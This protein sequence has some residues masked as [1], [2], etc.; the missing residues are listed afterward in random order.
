M[1]S[2][3]LVAV[4]ALVFAMPGS[5]QVIPAAEK[6]TVNLSVGGGFDYWWGDWGGAVHRFGPSAWLT[7][8]I[9]HG[10]GINV[11][12]HSMI[13]GGGNNASDHYK[14][15]AGKGGLI[16]TY[17]RWTTIRPYAKAEAGYASLS[18]PSTGLS[19]THQNEH[20]WSVGGGG[21]YRVWKRLWTRVDYTYDL[22][23][24]FYSPITHEYHYLTPSG[25]T[26][27]GTYHF[28]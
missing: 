26:F 28:R 7:A 8:D 17:H 10:F 5:A 13:V 11:E 20:I 18:F 19:Y 4:A 21:E 9:W 16:Y 23:P 2:K 3:L 12:G 1:R 22:F 15:F 6:S 24:N 27:G 14:Y 25:I